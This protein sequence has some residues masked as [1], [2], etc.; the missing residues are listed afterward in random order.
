MPCFCDYILLSLSLLFSL[1]SLF[2]PYCFS[3]VAFVHFDIAYCIETQTYDILG[4]KGQ[5]LKLTFAYLPIQIYI[6]NR[7][8]HLV[9][10]RFNDDDEEKNVTI[11]KAVL[12]LEIQDSVRS[13]VHSK[14]TYRVSKKKCVFS[15]HKTCPSCSL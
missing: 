10:Q 14:Y 15:Q 2:F 6:N 12:K 8:N 13:M 9:I 7:Q 11:S 5:L 1:S 4:K 3:F